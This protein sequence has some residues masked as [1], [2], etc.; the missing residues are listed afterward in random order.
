MQAEAEWSNELGHYQSDLQVRLAVQNGQ[1][2]A[3]DNQPL[4]DQS[5]MLLLD[6]CLPC[7]TSA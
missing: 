4:T 7:L 2:E 1:L 3:A 5:D 6:R